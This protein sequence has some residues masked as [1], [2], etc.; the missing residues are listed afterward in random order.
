MEQ[1]PSGQANTSLAIQEIPR[2]L[3][4]PKYYYRIY[5]SPLPVPTLSQFSPVHDLPSHLFKT[6]FNIILPS[7][8]GSPKVSHLL[9]RKG[10][11]I[12]FLIRNNKLNQ[13]YIHNT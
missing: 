3:W 8:P 6:H 13:K 7:T 4:N 9:I 1:S 5:K 12:N 11:Y 10:C 2:I